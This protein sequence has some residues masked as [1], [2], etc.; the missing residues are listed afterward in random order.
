[1]TAVPVGNAFRQAQ[2]E[3]TRVAHLRFA[4]VAVLVGAALTGCMVGPDFLK[5]D[6]PTAKAYTEGSLPEQTAATPGIGGAPQ[7]LVSGQDI[8]AQWWALFRSPALDQL[9]RQALAD[10]PTLAAAEATL[11]QARENLR[12]ESGALL[13]PAVDAK[14]SATREKTSG[15]AGGQPSAHSDIFNLYNA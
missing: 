8:P 11:R 12:A 15:A 10:S 6:P 9:I 5:P 2:Q 1:M 3:K 4:I 7:R 13:Y 14:A